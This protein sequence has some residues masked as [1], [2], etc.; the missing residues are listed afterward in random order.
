MDEFY[1]RYPSSFNPV[2]NATLLSQ[3]LALKDQPETQKTHLIEGRYENVYVACDLIQGLNEL[4]DE[5]LAYAGKILEMDVSS[6][7]IGF[8]FN[9]MHQG[10][11]TTAHTHNE[12][13][14]LLSGVYYIDVP[15]NSGDLILADIAN[16]N[17]THLTPVAS[18]FIF[19]A[20][21]LL[22]SV[23]RN[24]SDQMRLSIGMN[25]GPA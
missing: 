16:Q 1:Y 15:V 17:V 4:L 21:D 10:H 12:D 9:E 23:E 2:Q 18:E 14:E 13:D 3:Y 22:H 24:Q 11:S 5:A 7:K 6:L 19:F 25:I 20:P 8:W